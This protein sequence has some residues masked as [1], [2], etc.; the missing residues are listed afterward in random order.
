MAAITFGT[1]GWRALI[2]EDYTFDNVR[3]VALAFARY[4]RR[5]PGIANGVLVGGD[6]RFGSQDFAA[7]A[8]QVIASQGIKV[9]LAE[10]VISTPMLSLGIIKKKAAAGVMITA[11]HNPPEWNGF[12]IKAEFG[13]SALVRDIKKVEALVHGIVEK[14][15]APKLRPMDELRKEGLVKSIDL[16]KLYITDIRKKIDLAKIERSKMKIA[17]DVMYGASYGVM[18][19]L[20][21][22]VTCL[23]DEHNPGFKGIAPE[24]LAKNLEEFIALVTKEKYDIGLVT[25]GDADRFGCV[26]ENGNFISTQLLIPILLKYLHEDLGRTG[27]VVKTVS[28]TD[29]VPRMCEKYG[30]KLHERPVGFKYVTELMLEDDILIGG[31]ESGGVGTSLHIPERD[32]I[33]NNLLLCEYLAKK[34]M[35]LGQA[36]E[37]IFEEFGRVWYDRIDYRTTEKKKKAILAACAKGIAKLGRYAVQDTETT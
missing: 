34:K 11:S 10:N 26:D 3:K 5:H 1:D 4:Y 13:G 12:K 6:A 16:H 37:Q 30:L 25:D 24:P 31:E 20:L 19:H 28:V 15:T 14:G 17:Y 33:F 35:T 8:A 2:A 18:Q 21:P 32:G 29:I 27:A 9:W 23:H 36:V 22:K 7:A